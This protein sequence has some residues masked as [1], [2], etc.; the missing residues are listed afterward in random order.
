MHIFVF[1][2]VELF[3]GNYIQDVYS[4]HAFIGYIFCFILNNCNLIIAIIINEKKHTRLLFFCLDE[5]TFFS[6]LH[7][8]WKP[9]H[10]LQHKDRRLV[11]N[12]TTLAHNSPLNCRIFYVPYSICGKSDEY[13]FYSNVE[14]CDLIYKSC[15]KMA[16]YIWGYWLNFLREL[17]DLLLTSL[18]FLKRYRKM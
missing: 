6:K 13:I 16:S 11:V 10:Q 1:L 18:F 12:S 2:F 4:I 9:R 7:W 14:D 17:H 3:M 5:C 15:Y 8:S